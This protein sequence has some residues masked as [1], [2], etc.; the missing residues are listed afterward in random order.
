MQRLYHLVE[1]WKDCAKRRIGG[2]LRDMRGGVALEFAILLPVV[3]TIL[4]GIIQYGNILYVRQ[5]MTQAAEEAARSY[6]YDSTTAANAESLA[7]NRLVSTGLTYSV[8]LTEPAAD[9]T[10]V[11]VLITT[12]MN[13]AALVNVLGAVISGNI[14][15]SVILRME[16]ADCSETAATAADSE[17]TTDCVIAATS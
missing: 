17:M 9:E 7:A 1:P 14:E 15:V 6:A 12:P 13:E 4:F 5:L 16:S 3:L 2:L 8:T 10:N 11:R